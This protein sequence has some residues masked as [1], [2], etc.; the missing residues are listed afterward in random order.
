MGV[1]ICPGPS[2][3]VRSPCCRCPQTERFPPSGSSRPEIPKSLS[4]EGGRSGLR[5][6]GYL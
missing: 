2:F 4:S 1:E 6:A 5:G 3:R